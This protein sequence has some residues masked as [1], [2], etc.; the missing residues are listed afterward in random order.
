MRHSAIALIL[1][2]IPSVAAVRSFIPEDYYS[3]QT[4]EDTQ[5]SPD[6]RLVAYTL[7]S[8]DARQNRTPTDIWIVPTDG[9][10]EASQFTTVDSSRSPRW[11]PDN[12]T[13]AYIAVRRDPHVEPT[14]AAAPAAIRS[15]FAEG[16]I[17]REERVVVILTGNGLKATDKIV[18]HVGAAASSTVRA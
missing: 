15:L 11:S 16:T 6:G 9:S 4:P 10:R 2:A 17:A 14:A 18:A 3:I 5:I 8:I 13:L 1:L 7:R 12:R